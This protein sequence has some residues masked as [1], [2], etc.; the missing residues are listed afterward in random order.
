MAGHDLLGAATGRPL[1]DLLG[2]ARRVEVS[3]SAL[4]AAEDDMPAS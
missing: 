3:V 2:G 1:A 4:F